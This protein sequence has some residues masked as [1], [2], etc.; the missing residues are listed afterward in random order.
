MVSSTPRPHFTPGKD[1]V[2]ILQEAGWAPEP[3]WTG[4][5]SRPHRD[6]IPD[7]P[8]RSQS[9]CRLSHRATRRILYFKQKQNNAPPPLKLPEDSGADKGTVIMKNKVQSVDALAYSLHI[10][11]IFQL[12]LLFWVTFYS[13]S[14][15]FLSLCIKSSFHCKP[16][17]F[18]QRP[19]RFWGTTS[20]VFNGYLGSSPGLVQPGRHVDRSPPTPR[21]IIFIVAPCIS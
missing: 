18:T 2:P 20:L 13:V 19:H 14:L 12:L 1:P 8:A 4:G 21:Q 7:R 17:H 15:H 5:K 11:L 9:L 16:N 10:S 6:S 3:G